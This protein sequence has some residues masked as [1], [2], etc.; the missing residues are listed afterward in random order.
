MSSEHTDSEGLLSSKRVWYY[1]ILHCILV[2]LANMID[3]V[4]DAD[5]KVVESIENDEVI[6]A[7]G[8]ITLGKIK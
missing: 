7:D 3:F 5:L 8:S 4:M 6:P 2:I 1:I